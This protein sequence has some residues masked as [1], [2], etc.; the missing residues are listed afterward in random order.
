MFDEIIIAV[1]VLF[2]VFILQAF[3]LAVAARRAFGLEESRSIPQAMLLTLAPDLTEGFL[4]NLKMYFRLFIGSTLIA[5][6]KTA[7]KFNNMSAE[8]HN[9]LNTSLDM[10]MRV[11][12]EFARPV[13]IVPIAKE[14]DTL[15]EYTLHMKDISDTLLREIADHDYQSKE[16]QMV[17]SYSE[18]TRQPLDKVAELVSVSILG[19]EK[20]YILNLIN[21]K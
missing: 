14:V 5:F 7:R 8:E 3:L 20:D 1:Y 17:V 10:W 4:G 6:N 11:L 2:G 16:T 18:R 15:E 13:L 21:D 9:A 12:E 19:M